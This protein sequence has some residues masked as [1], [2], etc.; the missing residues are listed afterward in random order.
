MSYGTGGDYTWLNPVVIKNMYLEIVNEQGAIDENDQ[1]FIDLAV[2]I[3]VEE[4]TISLPIMSQLP[5]L[6]ETK[7]TLGE[8]SGFD[9]EIP[10][11]LQS[12]SVPFTMDKLSAMTPSGKGLIEANLRDFARAVNLFKSREI[13]NLI[14][15]GN[16][17]VWATIGGT[18]EYYFANAHA[19]GSAT[20]DNLFATALTTTNPCD[21][22]AT[23]APAF[24]QMQG[25]N[26][27]PLGHGPDTLV[28]SPSL[29][30]DALRAF[31]TTYDLS[32]SPSLK[33]VYSGIKTVATIYGDGTT[34]PSASEY[35]VFSTRIRKPFIIVEMKEPEIV[36]TTENDPDWKFNNKFRMAL[37]W[38]GKICY[39]PYFVAARG[40]S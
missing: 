34:T 31:G 20:N 3:P 1:K 10:V 22:L 9:V 37:H 16:A 28:V 19:W 33:N 32:G 12:Y 6:K 25:S 8:Q 5:L 26:G 30:Y 13:Q 24:A 15:N 35:F 39:G 18:A 29:E 11:S 38:Y 14:L 36:V 40:N 2:T 27:V 4:K 21:G 23:I 17:G 7:T